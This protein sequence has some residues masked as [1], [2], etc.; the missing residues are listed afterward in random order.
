MA[1]HELSVKQKEICRWVILFSISLPKHVR[2]WSSHADPSAVHLNAA[3][4]NPSSPYREDTIRIT[5]GFMYETTDCCASRQV[6]NIVF[7]FF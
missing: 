1:D 7:I 3:Q 5:K 2:I 4:K 6:I